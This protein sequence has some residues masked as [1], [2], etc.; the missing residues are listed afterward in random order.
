MQGWINGGYM[1]FQPE[2]FSYLTGDACVLE[3]DALEALARDGELMAYKHQHFW[4]CMDTVRDLN[5]LETLW[6]GGKPPRRV[7]G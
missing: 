5:V 4:Q 7:W 1:V 6:K 2:V 3:A